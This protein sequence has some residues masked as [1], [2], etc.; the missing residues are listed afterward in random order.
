[1]G[2]ETSDFVLG[3]TGGTATLTS[4]T[5]SSISINGNTYTL[6]LS[7][8]GTPN[9]SENLTANPVS[10]AIFDE[11]G[12][13]AANSQSNNNTIALKDKTKPVINPI[14]TTAFDWGALL[15]A[16]EASSA[17]TVNVTTGVENNQV[18]TIT[19]D[20]KT[21]TA[22][23]TNNAASVSIPA[24][25]LQALSDGNYTLTA[26]VSDAAGNAADT[27]TSASF[28]VDKTAPNISSI[29]VVSNNTSSPSRAKA[30]NELTF[31]VGFSEAVT[32]S[33]AS[34]VKVPFKIGSSTTIK[35]AAAQTTQTETIGGTANAINFKYTV[36]NAVN[37]LVTLVA[38]PLTLS[39]GATV[40][41]IGSS[42]LTGD[43]SILSGSV[44]VD[45]TPP[46]I[47]P[48]VTTAFSWGAVLNAT[49]DNSVGTVD[50][51]TL[52]VENGQTL[53]ITLNSQTY[54]ATVTNNAARVSI[55][56]ADLQ[57]LSDGQSYTLTADVSDATGNAA[58][59]VTSSPFNVDTS[60]PIINAIGTSAFSWGAVLNATEDNSVGTVD[61]TTLGVEDGQTLTITLN[62]QTYQANISNNA[63]RVSIPAADLQ[64]LSDGQ[65]YSLTADV[66]DAAGNVANT[67]TSAS[68]T[69]D[70]TSPTF[71]SI[72]VANDNSTVTITFS[73]SVFNTNSGNG[74]LETSD[75]VLGITGGT[76]TLTSTTPSSITITGNSYAL[77]LPLQGTPNGSEVL[78]VN[79][80]SN[81]IFDAAGNAAVTPQINNNTRNLKDKTPP[82]FTLSNLA[83]DN[84]TVTVTFSESV[85]NTNGGNGAL[86]TSDFV[87]GITGGTATVASTPS[88][89]SI[90]NNVYTLGL[91]LTGTPNGSE[92]L[93][94]NPASNAIFDTAGNAAVTPQSNSIQLL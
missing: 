57:A 22:S 47:N 48:I 46:T 82:T 7:L 16:T 72:D 74:A 20:G 92:T 35:Y 18:L 56:A 42:S 17:Q 37:G 34:D 15:N 24:A 3:I 66:S 13:A 54:T 83:N 19:L 80:A 28:T 52:G 25:D 87:L 65:S 76:A 53:T 88:S 38:G 61:V 81:A 5:P 26:D 63:V 4:T 2:L 36:E 41:D 85:F 1:M 30:G 29:S 77:G 67:V 39:N 68:F 40:L 50:V 43:M 91:S 11:A 31:K 59:T 33:N 14:A 60:S 84:S 71:A 64:A 9:G 32:L 27:V 69:V 58:N 90:N 44:T 73:E 23:V 10:N 55:P 8:Q 93:T 12:N 70:T 89:I 86:E 78:S 94:V 62:S 49:E 79:P 75:F 45:T 6:G 21:H 51:T